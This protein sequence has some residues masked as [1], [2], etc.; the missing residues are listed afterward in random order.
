MKAA[1][2]LIL[3]TA[4]LVAF[5]ASAP[6]VAKDFGGIVGTKGFS[7]TMLSNHFKLYQGYVANVNKLNDELKTMLAAGQE[8]SPAFAELKRRMGW[9]FNGMRL[10]ELY[11]A[12]I[13]SP[14]ALST[15]AS[16]HQQ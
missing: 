14:T 1:L 4:T 9:E 2:T 7:P 5:G 12:N 15:N 10:H 3:T 16:L 8:A 13:G 11:F 6:Y